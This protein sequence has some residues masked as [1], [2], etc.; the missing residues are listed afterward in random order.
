[1]ST[2]DWSSILE[3]LVIMLVS[4]VAGHFYTS[5]RK[6]RK[7][8]DAAFIKLRI[9]EGNHGRSSSNKQEELFK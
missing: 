6:L 7:D 2:V 8:M 9:L 4:G 3:K 5:V 1:M